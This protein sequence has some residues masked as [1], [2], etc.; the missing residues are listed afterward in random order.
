MTARL[1]RVAFVIALVAV[2]LL[3]GYDGAMGGSFRDR[4]DVFIYM[5]L[6]PT[7]L[8]LPL[9]FTIVFCTTS[10]AELAARFVANT[11][12]REE[13]RRRLIRR[14]AATG[15]SAALA[16]FVYVFAPFVV[17]FALWPAWGD[18]AIDPAGYGLDP[19]TLAIER[20][21]RMSYTPLLELGELPFGVIYAA[22]VGAG[23]A[24]CALAG[25]AF[26]V[27][28]SHR[29]LALA[30]PFLIFV[31]WTAAA[32]VLGTPHAGVL[33]SFFPG[34]LDS[35]EPLPAAI[36]GLALV[37]AALGFAFAIVVRAPR[38]PRLG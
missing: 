30:L 31:G 13:I 27:L 25:E 3:R 14:W 22:F 20:L 6:A 1:A 16:G 9:L 24:A 12:N 5:L 21:E 17:A 32:A 34:G 19:S 33:Y 28:L 11:R 15:G 35:I 38:N 2:P 18:P 26:L 23:M 4:L 29:V 10:Y 37:T 8:V 7:T 36:P